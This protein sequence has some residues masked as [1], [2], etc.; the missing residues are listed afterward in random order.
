[1]KRH[2]ERIMNKR[3]YSLIVQKDGSS[4]RVVLYGTHR[5]R[6]CFVTLDYYYDKIR[7]YAQSVSLYMMREHSMQK[8][9]YMYADKK[10]QYSHL[11]VAHL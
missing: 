8:S 2:R 9:L 5:V 3:V 4:T 11:N 6:L 7:P 10:N 1:M